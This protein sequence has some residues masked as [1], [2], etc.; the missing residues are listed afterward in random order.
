MALFSAEPIRF[1]RCLVL[2][3]PLVSSIA[4]TTLVLVWLAG[5]KPKFICNTVCLSAISY[6]AACT[7]IRPNNTI[8]Y[9]HLIPNLPLAITYFFSDKHSTHIFSSSIFIL[10]L[11]FKWDEFSRWSISCRFLFWMVVYTGCLEFGVHRK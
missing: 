8:S 10:E 7:T 3:R 4:T 5:K 9:H 11:T 6:R 2:R 1:R